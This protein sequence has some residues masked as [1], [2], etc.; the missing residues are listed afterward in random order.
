MKVKIERQLFG[1]L[2]END[3]KTAIDSTSLK[4]FTIHNLVLKIGN[5]WRQYDHI[6]ITP[7]KI[8]PI[9]AKSTTTSCYR[10]TE[11]LDYFGADE[12]EKSYDTSIVQQV[13]RSR[14]SLI[15]ILNSHLIQ[16]KSMVYP[17]GC[18][19][20][21]KVINEQT[22]LSIHSD[23]TLWYLIKSLEEEFVLFPDS[24]K[25]QVLTSFNKLIDTYRITNDK[26][27]LHLKRQG[28]DIHKIMSIEEEHLVPTK[29][30]IDED[31]NKVMSN[32][33][34]TSE[35]L[36][37]LSYLLGKTMDTI[38]L[39]AYNYALKYSTVPVELI[40]E[41][42][43]TVED[44]SKDY[45]FLKMIMNK[46]SHLIR[47]KYILN[48]C[49]DNNIF[50]SEFLLA[51]IKKYREKFLDSYLTLVAGHYDT[52]IYGLNLEVILLDIKR[53]NL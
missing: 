53:G 29:M 33:N 5:T 21:S 36:S 19:R 17:V 13:L 1:S 28:V 6:I 52:E 44:L 35:R 16:Y 45:P 50:F 46:N 30:V 39:D 18:I 41:Y 48:H 11:K 43:V 42:I 8:V 10:V 49:K 4:D 23:K 9:E 22:I 14:N 38:P 47:F 27:L 20:A 26:Y 3:I 51:V 24:L 2:L 34:E 31:E 37:K 40:Y 7:H 25:E 12:Q 15:D 32:Y